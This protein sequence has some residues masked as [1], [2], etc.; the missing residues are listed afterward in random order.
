[1]KAF[2]GFAFKR[3]VG[4]A[5]ALALV[6]AIQT[7]SVADV[8]GGRKVVDSSWSPDESAVAV[9]EDDPFFENDR[10]LDGGRFLRMVDIHH[11]K[12]LWTRRAKELDGGLQEAS[13]QSLIWIHQ[14][15][16]LVLS[17]VA[18]NSRL[19]ILILRANDGK[20]LGRATLAPSGSANGRFDSLV[21]S[22]GWRVGFLCRG[23]GASGPLRVFDLRSRT[24]TS[25]I[26]GVLSF[27]W[28]GTTLLVVRNPADKMG[29]SKIS[30]AEGRKIYPLSVGSQ[31]HAIDNCTTDEL[32]HLY[33]LTYSQ[34]A[35]QNMAVSCYVLAGHT[36]HKQWER[37]WTTGLRTPGADG[38]MAS[39]TGWVAVDL[40]YGTDGSGNNRVWCVSK[41]QLY[42]PQQIFADESY[43]AEMVSFAW[44]GQSLLFST[45]AAAQKSADMNDPDT[46]MV[47]KYHL[48]SPQTRSTHQVFSSNG[49]PDTWGASPTLRRA[50]R[51]VKQDGREQTRVKD[52]VVENPPC[53]GSNKRQ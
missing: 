21:D 30:I 3:I 48:F 7:V 14:R 18:P 5:F 26:Q 36:A 41:K 49:L 20:L 44:R 33:V 10:A 11:N 50:I 8:R 31:D 47:T 25:T 12:P 42:I 27:L 23:L 1:M 37:H 52:F 22:S 32:G 28:A 24:C 17:F 38:L 13:S 6:G 51:F 46:L 16:I 19:K 2:L 15:N 45:Y 43:L 39:S 4:T 53:S 9:L 34:R 29:Q 40:P 35:P